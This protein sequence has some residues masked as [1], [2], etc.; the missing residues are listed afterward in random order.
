LADDPDV[1]SHWDRVNENNQPLLVNRA[2]GLALCVAT[3]DKQTGQKDG[4]DPCT[5]SQKGPRTVAAIAAN[6][7]QMLFPEFEA[8]IAAEIKANR[9]ITWLLLVHRD[10]D[11]RT[12]RCE[13]SRPTDMDQNG[14]VNAWGQRIILR[15]TPFDTLPVIGQGSGPGP[16]SPEISI[17]IK[18][19]A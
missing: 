14:H 17:D 5:A 4:L 9:R 6:N 3:G 8:A 10:T 16:Q 13:L 15:D 12:L 1:A 18:R 7:G 19:R 11:S 2:R